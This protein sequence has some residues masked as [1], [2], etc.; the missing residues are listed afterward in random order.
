MEG[1]RPFFFGNM[2]HLDMEIAMDTWL[3]SSFPCANWIF[4][5]LQVKNH[6]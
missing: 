4:Q 5:Q 3:I 6:K 2:A 1:I